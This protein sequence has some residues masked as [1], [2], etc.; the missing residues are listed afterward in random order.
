MGRAESTFLVHS[1][2]FSLKNKMYNIYSTLT[3]NSSKI[4]VENKK[5][6]MTTF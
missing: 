3:V 4:F 5:F 6:K 2:T 1:L